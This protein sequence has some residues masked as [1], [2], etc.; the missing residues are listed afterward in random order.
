[1]KGFVARVRLFTV[2]LAAINLSLIATLATHLWEG[3]QT[4]SLLAT[5][6]KPIQSPELHLA[7]AARTDN[8]GVIQDRALFYAS[9]HFYVSPPPSAIPS[10]P[11]KPDYRLVG[12]FIIPQKPTVALLANSSGASRKVKTGDDLDGWSVQ[13]I[14]GRRVILQYQSETVEITAASTGGMTGMQM[15]PI[16]RTAQTAP[17]AGIRSLGAGGS[18][19]STPR[20]MDASASSP[21]LYRPPPK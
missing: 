2:I 6:A 19:S 12:T 20:F 4:A 15:A 13:A 9:R 8:V 5:A 16:T 7:A 17:V 21:R 10:T 11:P 18:L 1:V 3:T 14:E